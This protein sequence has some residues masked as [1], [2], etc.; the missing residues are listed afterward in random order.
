MLEYI[1]HRMWHDGDFGTTTWDEAKVRAE[2]M[3]EK[4]IWCPDYLSR[5]DAALT[6]ED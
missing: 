5:R 1:K 2:E 4:G 6:D 3:Y